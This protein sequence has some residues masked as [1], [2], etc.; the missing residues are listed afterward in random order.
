MSIAED[1]NNPSSRDLLA[2]RPCRRSSDE[3]Y[4]VHIFVP[5]WAAMIMGCMIFWVFVIKLIAATL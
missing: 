3:R 5:L 4:P 2:S 1:L